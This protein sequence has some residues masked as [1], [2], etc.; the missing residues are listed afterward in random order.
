MWNKFVSYLGCSKVYK[1]NMQT[2]QLPSPGNNIKILKFVERVS[3]ISVKFC[4]CSDYIKNMSGAMSY[5]IK[6]LK[7]NKIIFSMSSI[8]LIFNMIFIRYL[9]GIGKLIKCQFHNDIPE[10]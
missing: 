2:L 9:L 10:C 7:I 5:C 8:N 3:L 4:I 6:P 1:K